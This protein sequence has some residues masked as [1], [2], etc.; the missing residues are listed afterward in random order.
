MGECL[1]ESSLH[2]KPQ[3]PQLL[4]P[5]SPKNVGPGT[6]W[7]RWLPARPPGHLLLQLRTST[8]IAKMTRRVIRLGNRDSEAP[9]AWWY[10]PKGTGFPLFRSWSST[11][12]SEL[13]SERRP[14]FQTWPFVEKGSTSLWPAS[15]LSHKLVLLRDQSH[16]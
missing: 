15:P 2:P 9:G 16:W 4:Q 3:H 13:D 14:V 10:L 8:G 6:V 12:R 7:V 5:H 1:A 11:H